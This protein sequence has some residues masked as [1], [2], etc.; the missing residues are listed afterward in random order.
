LKDLHI[1]KVKNN[2]ATTRTIA[3]GELAI[4]SFGPN[5]ITKPPAQVLSRLSTESPKKANV[6][7]VAFTRKSL[8]VSKGVAKFI[9]N[10]LTMFSKKIVGEKLVT[11]PLYSGGNCGE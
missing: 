1:F 2:T 6:A 10:A 8:N 4:S 11:N 7:P 5:G 9:A 3:D